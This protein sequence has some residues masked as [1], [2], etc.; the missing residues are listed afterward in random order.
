[1]N[2]ERIMEIALEEMQ[3]QLV[4]LTIDYRNVKTRSAMTVIAHEQERLRKEILHLS[5]EV[6][7]RSLCK[8]T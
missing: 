6:S 5:P 2:Q 8:I 7:F 4:E 3:K 1:M